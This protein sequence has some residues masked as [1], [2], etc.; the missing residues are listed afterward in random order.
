[1]LDHGQ[2]RRKLMVTVLEGKDR[3]GGRIHTY[4]MGG[5]DN[6]CDSEYDSGGIITKLE[7]KQY[8]QPQHQPFPVDTR[9]NSFCRES[10]IVCNMH[11]KI[12]D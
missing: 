3:V 2:Q 9:R 11:F 10:R 7:Q 8:Q 5:A 4:L 12:L 6:E 1:M